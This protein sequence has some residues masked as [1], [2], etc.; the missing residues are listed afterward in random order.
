MSANNG[1]IFSEYCKK[2]KIDEKLISDYIELYNNINKN[3]AKKFK[4]KKN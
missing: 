2:K 4:R 3:D 1:K